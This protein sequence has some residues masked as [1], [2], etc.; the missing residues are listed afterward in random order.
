MLRW[1]LSGLQNEAGK[2]TSKVLH[3]DDFSFEF[4]LEGNAKGYG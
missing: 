2:G 3:D 4:S 1:S